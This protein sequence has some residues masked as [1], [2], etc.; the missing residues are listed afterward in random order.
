MPPGA[1]SA[2]ILTAGPGDVPLSIAAVAESVGFRDV[3]YFHRAFRKRYGITPK[4]ASFDPKVAVAMST[5][6]PNHPSASNSLQTIHHW[7]GAGI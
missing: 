3:S 4:D 1:W 6:V 2:G 7:L 5:T